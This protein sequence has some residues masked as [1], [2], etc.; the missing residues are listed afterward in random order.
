MGLP[1]FEF[2]L[3]MQILFAW[4][5]VSLQPSLSFI[6]ISVNPSLNNFSEQW[7]IANRHY[8]TP[9]CDGQTFF[10]ENLL[11]VIEKKIYRRDLGE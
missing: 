11:V 7:R 5:N 2:Q 3:R 6:Q 9:D 8:F 1:T 10:H 4:R